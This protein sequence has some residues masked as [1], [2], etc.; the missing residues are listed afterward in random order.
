MNNDSLKDEA[1]KFVKEMAPIIDRYPPDVVGTVFLT[2]ICMNVDL[3]KMQFMKS[4]SEFWDELVRQ[5][6]IKSKGIPQDYIDMFKV[7]TIS[8]GA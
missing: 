8:K 3:T 2:S 4:I 1:D 5:K 6:V 7:P